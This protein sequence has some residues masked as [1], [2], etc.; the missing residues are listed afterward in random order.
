MYTVYCVQHE[1]DEKRYLLHDPR[2]QK[3]HILSPKLT[4]KLS[5]SGTFTFTVPAANDNADKITEEHCTIVVYQDGQFLWA[6]KPL[7][8][9]TDFYNNKTYT[10]E[11]VLG[12]LL[13]ILIP[14]FS[15]SAQTPSSFMG[16]ILGQYNSVVNSIVLPVLEDETASRPVY[17]TYAK[18]YWRNFAAPDSSDYDTITSYDADGYITGTAENKIVRR[19]EKPLSAFEVLQTRL[20]DSF[21]GHIA[22]TESESTTARWQLSYLDPAK[23]IAAQKI[24]FGENLTELTRSLDMTDFY[25]ALMPV[26]LDGNALL[27]VSG[28]QKLIRRGAGGAISKM[29]IKPNGYQFICNVDLVRKY[30]LIVKTYE[31]DNESGTAE[32]AFAR[33]APIAIDLQPPAE[34]IT[35]N[36]VDLHLSNRE[37]EAFRVGQ[38]IQVESAPHGMDAVMVLFELIIPLDDPTG[39]K[40]ILNGTL[41]TLTGMNVR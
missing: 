22:V 34:T 31:P 24:R 36:A 4:M 28:E 23:N 6:G 10:C 18:H 33:T 8:L 9:D 27:N 7:L 38:S 25:T 14:P 2:S 17:D 26:D 21:G 20:I 37:V 29:A 1:T 40:I 35:V 3:H 39:C 11:G 13:D 32:E 12:L 5:E 30:G 19:S 41:K 15:S 16:E